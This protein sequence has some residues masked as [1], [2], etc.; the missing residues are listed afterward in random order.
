MNTP[1]TVRNGDTLGGIAQRYGVST[2]AIQAINPVIQDMNYLR[3]GWELKIPFAVSKPVMPPPMF[4]DNVTS[5][6]L[7]G[8]PECD[9]ELVDVAHIT[10]ESHFYVLT[11]SQSKA[12]KQEI[13]VV[14]KLMDELHQNL[15][16]ALPILEC[17]KS[18][19]P[20]ASCTCTR[21]IKEAW[22]LKA[23]GAGLLMRDTLPQPSGAAPLMSAQDLQGQLATLQQARDWYQRYRP[24]PISHTGFED[25]WKKL[26]SKKVQALEA[27]M[28]ELRAK[29]AAR[30][31]AES[32]NSSTAA[33]NAA[34]N[35]THGRG[36]ERERQAGQQSK[37]GISVVEVILF[38]DPTRRHYI[39]VRY[40]DTA[41]WNVRASTRAMVGK[42]FNQQL[43]G[44]LMNDI[45]GAIANG[46]KA[47][48]LGNL[49]LKLSSWTSQ[50]D[51]LLN[52][53][54]TEVNWTSDQSDA[55]P[56]AVSA[57]AHAMRF[58][59]SASAGVNNWNPAQGSIDVGIKANAAFSLAEGL[60]SFSHYFPD[61][62]G[63]VANMAYRNAEGQEALHPLGVFRLSGKL[64][65]SCFLGAKFGVEAGVK[66]QYKPA[67]TPAGATALLGTPTMEVGRSGNIGVK[68]DAFAGVQA[69]GALSGTLQWIEPDK[70]GTGKVVP[71]QANAN[72]NWTT[73]AEIKVEGNVAFGGGLAGEFGIQMLDGR[74][75]FNC[76]GSVVF[77]PGAGGGFGTVV[78]IK[79]VGKL[80]RLLCN[81]LAEM[82]YRQLLGVTEDAF[83]YIAMGLYQVATSPVKSAHQAFDLARLG[84]LD[85]WDNRT[86]SIAEAKN[87]VA[88]V[89]RH[90]EDK[91][92]MVQGQSIPFSLLPPETLGPM[93]HVLLEWYVVRPHHEA[94]RAVVILVSEIRHWR[95][96]IEV[97]EHCSPRA[98]KVNAMD[99][100][101][102]INLLL[103]GDEQRQFNNFVES[104]A[105]HASEKP[106]PMIAWKAGSIAGKEKALIAA[107]NSG[108]FGGAA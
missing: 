79:E 70:Q 73:L 84:M 56:Y 19:K 38:S 67:E 59:A 3:V 48:P 101:E 99:T 69:G 55:A 17:K 47:G 39:P 44:D 50:D 29:L 85:W 54:H 88:Y 18:Q 87:L 77:G 51:N 2:T 4:E 7:E 6:A 21:C 82:D 22:A 57:E 60:V 90:E 71:G 61:Q 10:G 11:D 92:M 89:I 25:N 23:E 75:A 33:K 105:V 8:Q 93:I 49:E 64:E 16:K 103:D 5:T 1:Y 81:A 107:R 41:S 37:S 104:L 96:F 91:V 46:R 42:P 58:A 27:Q 78:D 32:A 66:M 53:L 14:Q 65:L 9:E 31:E 24:F 106:S 12:L 34:P 28:D 30:K 13:N 100:L 68:G 62:G 40:R 36:V 95:Q 63:Y 94:Q 26:Q 35:L 20:D 86:I 80:T 76:K 108:K 43:A 52:A 97:L 102:R 83:S 98:E 45:K 72:S 74:L 15:A